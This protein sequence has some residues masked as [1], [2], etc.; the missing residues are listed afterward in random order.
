[1]SGWINLALFLLVL[2]VGP[3]VYSQGLL[4]PTTNSQSVVI[5][6]Q[7]TDYTNPAPMVDQYRTGSKFSAANYKPLY[8]PGQACA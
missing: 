1:M 6:T 3:G 8:L 2:F 5:G 7:N 4:P